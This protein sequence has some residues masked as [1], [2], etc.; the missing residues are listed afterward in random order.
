MPRL[1]IDLYA[2]WWIAGITWSVVV[3]KMVP[4]VPF[5]VSMEGNA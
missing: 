1:V 5:V 4:L 3:W 2:C